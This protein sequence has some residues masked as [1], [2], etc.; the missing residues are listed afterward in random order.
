MAPILNIRV[1]HSGHGID[2]LSAATG[3]TQPRVK[4]WSAERVSLRPS[5]PD[6]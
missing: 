6:G 4:S 5:V 3:W 1:P 2:K